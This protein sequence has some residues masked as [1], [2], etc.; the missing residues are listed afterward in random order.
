MKNEVVSLE[1]ERFLQKNIA[2]MQNEFLKYADMETFN[3]E[4]LFA[5]NSL[6]A[7]NFLLETA[8]QDEVSLRFALLTLVGVGLTLNPQRKLAYLVPRMGRVVLDVSYRGLIHIAQTDGVI[9]SCIP[10]LIREKDTFKYKGKFEL[11]EVS[12]NPFAS[13]EE[14]G[15]IIGV[16]SVTTATD[17]SIIVDTMSIE[18]IYKIRDSS[19]LYRRKKQGPWVD[20]FEEMVKKTMIRRAEKNWPKG[21]NSERLARINHYI[22]TQSGEGLHPSYTDP[23]TVDVVVVKPNDATPV[24]EYHSIEDLPFEQKVK[25]QRLEARIRKDV[26]LF[27]NCVDYIKEKFP[28]DCHSFSIN[29]LSGVVEQIKA[30]QKNASSDETSGGGEPNNSGDQAPTNV[31]PNESD[32]STSDGSASSSDDFKTIEEG[33]ISSSPSDGDGSQNETDNSTPSDSSST[34]DEEEDSVMNLIRGT[35]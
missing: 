6:M 2:V 12:Y 8:R 9:K 4:T 13:S 15:N 27:N 3:R 30:E 19:D 1:A 25:L 22:D 32:K 14:R 34:S 16:Y 23:K 35:K 28:A 21:N 11:P 17:G 26:N 24:A 29:Y 20:W 33:T 5:L 18:E 10:E 31:G 7:N